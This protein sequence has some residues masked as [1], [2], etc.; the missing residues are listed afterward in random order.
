MARRKRAGFRLPDKIVT[1]VFEDGPYQGLELEVNLRVPMGVWW[2]FAAIADL[3]EPA[4]IR[5]VV[6]TWA[7]TQL[8]GWNMEDEAGAVPA[9][10]DAFCD[11]LDEVTQ[12]VI[13]ARWSKAVSE[14]PV[15][16]ALPSPAGDTSAQES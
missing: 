4:E 14:V 12:A 8:K 16:L 5:A 3:E 1:L 11:R 6:H 7:S 9:T 15:P 13:L 10:P 2:N